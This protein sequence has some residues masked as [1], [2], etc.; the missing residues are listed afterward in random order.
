MGGSLLIRIIANGQTNTE[1]LL[2]SIYAESPIGILLYD[3]TGKLM[4]VNSSCLDLFGVGN[5]EEIEKIKLFS[6]SSL[7]K[8]QEIKLEHKEIV[9]CEREFDF[10]AYEIKN[11]IKTS[12]KGKIVVDISITPLFFEDENIIYNFLV[13]IQDITYKK[14]AE[15]RIKESEEKYRLLTENLND[16]ITV[17]NNKGRI[18]YI[19]EQVH[20]KIMGYTAK[21]LMFNDVFEMIHPEDKAKVMEEFKKAFK[22]GEGFVEVRIANN[23]GKYIWTETN[24]KSFLDRDGNVKIL[25]IT[26]DISDRKTKEE[27]IQYQANL[28]DEVSDAIMS[29][30]LNFNIITWNNA[31]ESIYGWKEKE[32]IGKNILDVL[33]MVYPYDNLK[34]VSRKLCNTGNWKG[35]VIQH[36]KDG[37]RINVLAS[38]SFVKDITGKPI[39]AVA[40]NRDITQ[41]KMTEEKLLESEK[42]YK[43]LFNNMSNGVA[44][45]KVLD[46]GEDFIFKDFNFAGARIDNVRV[47]DVIGKKVTEVFPGVKDFGIFKVFQRVW[48]SG[49][50][51]HYPTKLYRDQRIA[52]WRD[53]YVYKLPLGE[54]VAI[55]NDVTEKK[56]AEDKL[57]ESELKFRTIAEQSFIGITITLE[58]KIVYA[59]TEFS[60]MV[61]YS[62]EEITN[63]DEIEFFKLIHPDDY[64]FVMKQVKE[65]YK[66]EIKEI[67]NLQFRLVPKSG[68][69]IWVET[70]TKPIIYGDEH[71]ILSVIVD[72]TEKKKTEQRLTESEEKYRN[73]FENSPYPIILIDLQGKIVDCNPATN[74]ELGYFKEELVGRNFRELARI[75]ANRRVAEQRLNLLLNGSKLDPIEIQI[76]KKD[77]KLIWVRSVGTL[78]KIRNNSYINIIGQNI[79]NQKLA[80]LVIL[81]SEE[82]FRGITE[83]SLLGIC[84]VQDDRIRYVNQEMANLYGYTPEEMLNWK[85]GDFIKTVAPNSIEECKKQLEKRT[86]G[87]PN[88]IIHFPIHSVKR[89][90]EDFWVDHI[91]KTM[92]YKGRRAELITQ[93]EITGQK[94]AEEELVKLNNLKMELLRR[95][96]HELKTPLVSI[97]G[98]TELLEIMYGD[99][100]DYEANEIVNGIKQGCARLENL[101]NDILR[102]SE[103]DSGIK[104][105]NIV[106]VKLISLI[107]SAISELLGIIKLRNH[108]LILNLDEEITVNVDLDQM[109]LVISNLLSNAIK[110]TPPNGRIEVKTRIDGDF[111]V[112]SIRDNGIGFTLEEKKHIFQQFGKIERYGR[113]FDVISE[114]SGLGL[115]NAKK[116]IEL[117]NGNIWVESDGREKGSTFSFSLPI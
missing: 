74:N 40:V 105:L 13:H 107:K 87:D 51:E 116:I 117:H 64:H 94:K 106:E 22:T 48:K 49:E 19:N 61:G 14:I 4:S 20:V 2:K 28:I 42:N 95:T 90:G 78:V 102:T 66:N 44:V 88:V 31:A 3:S 104:L 92:L 108:E 57:I 47:E 111:A 80:E 35:E 9:K 62:I 84:I 50:A 86:F 67:S 32:V 55:Y 83:Q 11:T 101:I 114:G 10:D 33:S 91:S 96:S 59:N 112:V 71:A 89:N 65:L 36:T 25:T 1:E 54:I 43:E 99:I 81:E 100:F 38:V 6:Y 93:F 75:P 34:D 110:Y 30:D 21:D 70:S 68:E 52:G 82:K 103:L 76:Q 73:L 97:K 98:Y 39:G 7:T 8:E 26:R 16:L 17:V 77:H 46:D 29:T 5:K 60:R 37:T 58:W 56:I 79:T 109:H 27:K 63:W 72:I 23:D 115:Y 41:L 53:N 12:K 113:G 24:G 15:Q 85:S 45:Y 69:I 18:E